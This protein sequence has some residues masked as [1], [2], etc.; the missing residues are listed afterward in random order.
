[1][2][3]AMMYSCGKDSSLAL[4]RM[5]NEGHTPVALI[6]AFNQEQGRSWFHGIPEELLRSVSES[7]G[8]PLII[9]HCRPEDYNEAIEEGLRK[10]VQ[11]GAESCVFGD[12]DIEGHREWNEQRCTH[13]GLTCVLPLWQEGRRAL[14]EELIHAGFKAAIKIVQSDILDDSFL[15]QTLT[16]DLVDRI[17]AAGA[18]P[19]GENGE[20][21]TFVYDGPLFPEP[22]PTKFGE[23]IDFK[24][25]K[26]IDIQSM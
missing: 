22:I 12:I 7:L 21:H 23:I 18:D 10:A 25:H 20:Y 8:I 9:C 15:G 24:T 13:A 11:L 14:T 26:A 16:A 5:I 3:F 6:S 4:Y 19:C 17:E 1:M 2:K